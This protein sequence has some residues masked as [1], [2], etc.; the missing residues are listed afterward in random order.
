MIGLTTQIRSKSNQL[1]IQIPNE[2]KDIDL[3]VIILPANPNQTVIDFFSEK[4]LAK[5]SKK[6]LGKLIVDDEDYSKW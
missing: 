1:K 6:N 5:L 3:Q 4:E 2:L